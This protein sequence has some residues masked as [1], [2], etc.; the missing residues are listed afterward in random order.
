M[1][2][3]KRQTS[4]STGLLIISICFVAMNLR[5]AITSVGPLVSHIKQQFH[6]SNGEVGLVTTLPLIGFAVLSLVA[7]VLSRRFGITRMLFFGLLF[8]TAGIAVRSL[9]GV[10]FLF[11]GTALA[12]LAIAVCNVLLPGLVK[13][14]FP[15]RVGMLTGLYSTV[16]GV[17]AALA[18][19]LSVPL[20][21][22]HL[23]NWSGALAVWMIPALLGVVVW[24]P[25]IKKKEK[26]ISQ[27][28]PHFFGLLRSPLA[29]QMTIYMGC[30]SF[31]FYITIAWLPEILLDRGLTE[32][33]AGWM[34]SLI[35]LAGLPASLFIPMFADRCTG[36][37]IFVGIIAAF[38]LT[39][40]TGLL[41]LSTEWV[42]A[43]V[44]L[45]GVGQ[46]AS[47][48]LALTLLGLRARTPQQVAQLSGMAQS[49]GYS[50]AAVGPTLFG[51]LKD[52]TGNWN[53]P[54]FVLIFSVCCLF[55][56]G[57]GAGRNLYV[58]EETEKKT[59][60]IGG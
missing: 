46:G 34:L 10:M 1:P 17:F 11:L 15:D 42:V 8:L 23:L 52:L 37:R 25:H 54:L 26:K 49:I 29:W 5:P 58:Y 55:V 56:A 4:R 16:M 28:S 7:P 31:A 14:K 22:T 19:G 20:E 41:F 13:Q 2:V 21:N 51:I 38:Y 6:L 44:V 45:T 24:F 18:S 48:S 9:P 43:A 36:Q 40:L 53:I 39:G 50:L 59:A 27:G 12:G 47:F 32:Q 35:Q 30:T 3:K 57:L 33:Q 60:G